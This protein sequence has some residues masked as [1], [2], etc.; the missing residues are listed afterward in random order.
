LNQTVERLY[1]LPGDLALARVFN[2]Q[3][4]GGSSGSHMAGPV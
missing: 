4:L 2:S 1:S 3:R